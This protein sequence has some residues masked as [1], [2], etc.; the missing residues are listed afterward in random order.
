MPILGSS[1]IA[2]VIMAVLQSSSHWMCNPTLIGKPISRAVAERSE[3]YSNRKGALYEMMKNKEH[4]N[5]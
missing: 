2:V 5:I 3:L 1:E 4:I